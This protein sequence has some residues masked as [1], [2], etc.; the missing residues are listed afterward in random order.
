MGRLARCLGF[1]C[2]LLLCCG[3]AVRCCMATNCFMELAAV[4]CV[5]W[6]R[7]GLV[8]LGGRVGLV[9]LCLTAAADDAL[10]TSTSYVCC[11]CHAAF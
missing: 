4:C 1:A 9:C 11:V 8:G 6:N 5:R 2:V 10:L 7:A 3:A